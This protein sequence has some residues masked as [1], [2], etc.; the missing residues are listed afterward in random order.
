MRYANISRR[1]INAGYFF[2][3]QDFELYDDGDDKDIP[4]KNCGLEVHFSP[5]MVAHLEKV[6]KNDKKAMEKLKSI[7]GVCFDDKFK[8]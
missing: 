6:L 3:I 4:T 7:K 1:N 8:N 2:G 5:E